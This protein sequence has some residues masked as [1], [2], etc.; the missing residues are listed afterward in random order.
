MAWSKTPGDVQLINISARLFIETDN[1]SCEETFDQRK[2][3]SRWDRSVGREARKMQANAEYTAHLAIWRSLAKVN[4][5][6]A[7]RGRE[8]GGEK[9]RIPWNWLTSWLS[10]GLRNNFVPSNQ[11]PPLCDRVRHWP[12][13]AA[14][15]PGIGKGYITFRSTYNEARAN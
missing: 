11:P 3:E 6:R 8:I 4:R 12:T 7:E 2:R 13:L 15:K 1:Q 14:G 10:R 9:E 5:T